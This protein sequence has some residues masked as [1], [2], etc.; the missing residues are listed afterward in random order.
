[1]VADALPLD[2]QPLDAK[3]L[4]EALPGRHVEVF[5]VLDS[6]QAECLARLDVLPDRSL[7]LA[8]RQRHGRG[9]RGRVW[10]SPAGANLYLSM[11][12]HPPA[13]GRRWPGVVTLALGVA[14][15]EAMQ[16]LGALQVGLKWPNDLW[17][18]DRKLGG[19]LV[20]AASSGAIVAGIGINVRVPETVRAAI[21]QPCIDLHELGCTPSRECLAVAV[22]Q[23][24]EE[25]LTLLSAQGWAG[26]ASRWQRLDLLAG[27]NVRVEAGLDGVCE[28]RACGVDEAG[29]LQVEC[30][31]QRCAFLSADVSVRPR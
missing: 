13:P 27:R 2:V 11:L 26:F 16:R 9:R 31:G 14:A 17:A 6:T 19:I 3:A 20:E 30:A 12:A 28:G 1:M 8:A 5:E 22:A 23:A 15:A 18:E 29:R 10:Q 25:A 4:A 7:V 21:G 24:W